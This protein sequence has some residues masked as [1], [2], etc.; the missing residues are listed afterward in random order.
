V[1]YDVDR[2]SSKVV[3]RAIRQKGLILKHG[4]PAALIVGVEGQDLEDMLLQRNRKFWKMIEES[5]SQPAVY[6]IEQVREELGLRSP[7]PRKKKARRLQSRRRT[8]RAKRSA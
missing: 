2:G 7:R 4:K 1:F 5:R 6:T 3:I 8:H